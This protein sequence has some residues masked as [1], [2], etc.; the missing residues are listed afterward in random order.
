MQI[1]ITHLTRMGSPH[2]C[3][4]GIDK[5]WTHWR[6][7][8]AARESGDWKLD[9]GWLRSQGGLLEVGAVID[10]G[11]V[12]PAPTTPEKEDVVV[13]F[14]QAKF[15]KYLYRD[16]FV[17]MLDELASDS[18]ESIFGTELEKLSPTATA[19]LA[20]EGKAS[21]GVLRLSGAVLELYEES[22]I[23]LIFEDTGLGE[24]ELKVTDL[25]LWEDYSPKSDQIKRI[26]NEVED[27]L[28][29][30]G[31]TGVYESPSYPGPR[32]WLQVNNIFPRENP[33]WARE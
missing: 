32:H 6:P 20:G 13:D 23:R 33:L 10:F 7:V 2:I 25:R 29:T 19:T 4:A 17:R 31:L 22:E 9:R 27:C 30:V 8:A 3:V 28:V 12:Q 26:Q 1:A 11:E 18:L 15:V 24:L 14:G 16:R 21:L 5:K